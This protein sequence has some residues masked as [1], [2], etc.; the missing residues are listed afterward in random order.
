MSIVYHLWCEYNV[1]DVEAEEEV[2]Q[3]QFQPVV[4]AVPEVPSK[5]PDLSSDPASFMFGIATPAQRRD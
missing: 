5:E 2:P 4:T 3:F 1:E